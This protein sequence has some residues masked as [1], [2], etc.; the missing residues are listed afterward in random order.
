M[1][2]S[3]VMPVLNDPRVG[4]ALETVFAQR[5]QHEL[6][7]I[8]VD[9]GSDAATL[10]V[11]AEYES[12]LDFC[13]S[14]PDAGLYDG[15][16]KGIRRATGDVV[17]I[18]NA[19]DEYADAYVLDAVMRVFEDHAEVQVCCGD[20]AYM[21]K[22]GETVRYWRAGNNHKGKWY[23]GW[24][25]PHPGFFVRRSVYE[26]YGVFNMDYPIAAD[27][28]LQLRLLFLNN[29]P[30][31]HIDRVLV[32]MALGGVSNRSLGNILKANL[33]A[34]RAWRHHRLRGGSLVPILKPLGNCFQYFRRPPRRDASKDA[35]VPDDF[36][37]YRNNC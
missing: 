17:G 3:I 31:W 10:G 22:R 2:I 25:P 4:R 28:E 20:I 35:K 21:D 1:K 14:E 6:E 23:F 27:Y 9:G 34:G 16:N 36:V 8:V 18:L 32:K 7:T 33:E 13:I 37:E 5:H 19:D 12:R 11:L 24:R 26:R 29:L 15:M 30:S